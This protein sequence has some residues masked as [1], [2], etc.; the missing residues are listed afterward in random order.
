MMHFDC[1]E[2]FIFSWRVQSYRLQTKLWEDNVFTGVCLP[3]GGRG[4]V[5]LAPCPFR[6]VGISGTTALLGVGVGM[7]RWWVCMSREGGYV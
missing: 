6:R 4:W 1:T 3:T 2:N 7:S 5:S